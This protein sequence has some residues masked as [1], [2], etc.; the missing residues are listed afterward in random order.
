MVA[1][2]LLILEYTYQ[3]PYSYLITRGCREREQLCTALREP[4]AALMQ[5]CSK[6]D[7]MLRGYCTGRQPKRSGR[8]AFASRDK[9][10]MI[11]GFCPQ[12]EHLSQVVRRK[13]TAEGKMK[14]GCTKKQT[15]PDACLRH[16]ENTGLKKS[17]PGWNKQVWGIFAPLP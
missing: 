5:L 17:F 1:G 6:K 13:E 11:C 8:S 9:S 10:I 7:C 2:A 3:F 12:F 4:L 16:F 15:S 14:Y